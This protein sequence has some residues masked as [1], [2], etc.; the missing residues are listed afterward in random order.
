MLYPVD[1]LMLSV[2]TTTDCTL[3]FCWSWVRPIHS[4]RVNGALVTMTLR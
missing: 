3:I 1:A 4:N 2:E